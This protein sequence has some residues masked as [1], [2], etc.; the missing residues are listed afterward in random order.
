MMHNEKLFS[1]GTLRYEPVQLATFGRLLE[2]TPDILSGF[3]LS[4]IKIT[5]SNV[6]ETSGES[7]H[8][9]VSFTGNIEDQIQGL[10]F[11]ISKE[12]LDKADAYEVDDYK[13]IQVELRSG[14]HAWVYVNC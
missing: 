2:G 11:D 4:K 5:D 3:S 8:P 6:V 1:Y 14:I 10:V 12:E 13:R 9:I 7:E